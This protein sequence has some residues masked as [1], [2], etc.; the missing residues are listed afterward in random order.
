MYL[1]AAVVG[2]NCATG[3]L[4]VRKS[5]YFMD[6]DI[7]A[8]MSALMRKNLLDKAGGFQAFGCYLAEDFFFAKHITVRNLIFI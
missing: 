7:F 2:I 4:F 6:N 3:L 1:S 8:G 5:Q